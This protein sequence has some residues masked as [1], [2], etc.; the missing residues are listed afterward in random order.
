MQTLAVLLIGYSVFSALVIALTHFRPANYVGQPLARAAG[1][2]LLL[3]LAAMQL[4]HLAY[5]QHQAGLVHEAAYRALLFAVAPCFYLFSKPLLQA[6]ATFQGGYGLHLVPVIAAVWIPYVWALPLAFVLGAVYLLWL[7]RTVHA[8][9]AQR[10]RFRQELALLAGV[11]AMALVITLLG[12][13]VGL[14]WLSEHDFYLLYA[15][16]IGMAFLLVSV[17]LGM[18]PQLAREVG[19]AAQETYAVSTLKHVDCAAV[20]ARLEA[21]MQEEGLYRQPTI[22]LATLAGQVGISGHQLSELINTRLGKNFSRYLRE[23]RVAAAQRMLLDEPAA[24][25]LS[26]GLSVGFTSQSGFYDAFREIAGM[27]PGNF[28]KLRTARTPD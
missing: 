9:R 2:A 1:L 5:L 4:L 22:D 18:S 13:G 8:L 17:A 20:L 3:I 25:V 12:L 10:D 23:H 7:A 11:F 19:E 21:L 27:T 6:Q 24:S 16:G 28:R 26:V 15:S 14:H